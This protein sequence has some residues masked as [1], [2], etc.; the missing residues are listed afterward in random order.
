MESR[1]ALPSIKAKSIRIARGATVNLGNY[2]SARFDIEVVGD[3]DG[4]FEYLDAW[5]RRVVELKVQEIQEAAGLPPHPVE[6][7]TGGEE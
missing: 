6:R 7:F 3:T 4:S 2:E 1:V 5:L